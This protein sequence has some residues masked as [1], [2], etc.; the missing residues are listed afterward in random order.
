MKQKQTVQ[1]VIVL[2][3]CV[4]G[5]AGALL[6]WLVPTRILMGNPAEYACA[7]VAAVLSTGAFFL[8]CFGFVF[9]K[10]RAGE[11][12]GGE[13]VF[14]LPA[15]VWSVLGL[16]FGAA[17]TLSKLIRAISYGFVPVQTEG[18]QW[19][20]SVLTLINIPV[21]CCFAVLYLLEQRG[22]DA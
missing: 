8:F 2:L 4:M 7:A 19:S 15:L 16:L 13:G 14:Y 11:G 9:P 10:I 20:F 21:L 3:C 17:A 22:R 18:I 5:A 6:H 12:L 1:T